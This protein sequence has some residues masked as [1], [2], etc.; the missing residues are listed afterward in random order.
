MSASETNNP[1]PARDRAPD[2]PGVRVYAHVKFDLEE[3]QQR[4]SPDQIG[5]VMRGIA[6]V[7]AADPSLRHS[8]FAIRH[9]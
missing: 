9:S 2:W 4:L 5:A 6:E 7:V 1:A 8:S 3:M